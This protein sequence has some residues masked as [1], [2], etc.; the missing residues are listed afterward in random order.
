MNFAIIGT[1]KIARIHLEH[2]RNYGFKEI[3]VVSRYKARAKK[4]I[5]NNNFFNKNIYPADMN[6]FKVKKF[7]LID[8][9]VNTNLHHI[10]LNKLSKLKSSIIVEKPIVSIG[11]FKNKFHNYLEK[12]FKKNKKIF[13]PYPMYNLAESFLREFKSKKKINK[14]EFFFFTGGKNQFNDISYDLLPHI[15]SFLIKVLKIKEFKTNDLQIRSVNSKKNSWKCNFYIRKVNCFIFLKENKKIKNSNFYF[16]INNVV[17]KRIIEQNNN[18]YKIYLK[19]NNK[20]KFVPNSMKEVLLKLCKNLKNSKYF[21]KNQLITKII[22]NMNY[23]IIH[24]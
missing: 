18:N 9:C 22:M 15:L 5:K 19:T 8:I 11:I 12:I 14:I 3:Y 6:I 23:K 17:F 1:S 7:K 2:I 24:E 13:V 20:K 4:F 16:K 10:Y 21:E